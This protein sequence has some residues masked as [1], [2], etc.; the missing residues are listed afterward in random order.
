MSINFF[1]NEI[2]PT[3]IAMDVKGFDAGLDVEIDIIVHE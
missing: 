2:L 3:R 1:D